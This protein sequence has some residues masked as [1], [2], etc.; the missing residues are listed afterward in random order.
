MGEH[1]DL[2]SFATAAGDGTLG[3][4][5]AV[6]G[7]SCGNRAVSG[8]GGSVTAG[9]EPLVELCPVVAGEIFRLGKAREKDRQGNQDGDQD[10][11]S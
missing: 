2:S 8:T 3:M 5:V 7:I 9:A 11:V 10:R 1:L 4:D 6:G